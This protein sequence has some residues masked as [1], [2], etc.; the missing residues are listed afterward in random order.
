MSKISTKFSKTFI[1]VETFEPPIIARFG[2]F[3]FSKNLSRFSISFEKLNPA[4]EGKY[5]VIPVIDA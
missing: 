1:F 2:F 4:Y 3:E 5:L